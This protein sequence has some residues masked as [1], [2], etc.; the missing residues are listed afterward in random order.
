MDIEL[1]MTFCYH[2]NNSCPPFRQKGEIVMTKHLT[3]E[4]RSFI[5]QGLNEGMGLNEIADIIG[6]NYSTV[7]REV[8]KRRKPMSGNISND[9]VHRNECRFPQACKAKD[10][11]Y[12]KSCRSCG[13]CIEACER[14]ESNRCRRLA[15][16]PYVCNGCRERQ[17][18]KI[19]KKFIYDPIKAQKMYRDTLSNSRRGIS[20]SE[21]EIA[22]IDEVVS[23]LIL[24][25]QS[26][27]VACHNNS[28]DIPVTD[29]TI[30]SY[31][32]AGLLSVGP[33]DLSRMVQRK[34]RRKKSGPVM[35]VDKKCHI[36]RTYEDRKTF[37]DDNPESVDVQM[38]TVEGKKGGKCLLTLYFTDCSLQL[39]FLRERNTAKTVSQEFLRLR[40]LLGN[41]RF[42]EM[43]ALITTDRG[44][45]FT[46][47][48]RIEYEDVDE[49]TGKGIGEKQCHVFYCD[50]QNTNQKSECERNHEYIRM[51]IPKGKS[52]NGLE[53]EDV[54]LMM[55][56]IN[57]YERKSLGMSTPIDEFIKKYGQETATLLGLE[58]IPPN[59]VVLKPTLLNVKQDR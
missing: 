4:Q 30:Y 22:H 9:C 50:P 18:C 5:H 23:P 56:H 59:D 3:F 21:E 28:D 11:I 31:L 52:M 36:G 35:R 54:R 29:R 58:K 26:V 7:L 17:F 6:K 57:S 37:L 1:S 43:F 34:S 42:S 33:L 55:N 20:L 27:K 32:K 24:Q 12:P 19:K 2:Q 38:D 16:A 49:E 40:K 44:S 25:G 41:E 8:K 15:G 53:D 45:E 10:C 46:D 47:P 48:C 14:Y 51:V 13:R 39:M